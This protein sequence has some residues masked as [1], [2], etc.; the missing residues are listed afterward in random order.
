MTV[1]WTYTVTNP[2]AVRLSLAVVYSYWQADYVGVIIQNAS[3]SAAMLSDTDLAAGRD[4]LLNLTDIQF[5]ALVNNGIPSA[6]FQAYMKTKNI[7]LWLSLV[8]TF[9]YNR[10]RYQ[11]TP[12]A[13]W[14]MT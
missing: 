7:T 3:T 14:T 10:E 2:Q 1:S 6:A 12:P 8:Q 4:V 11:V 5:N 13:G 9:E